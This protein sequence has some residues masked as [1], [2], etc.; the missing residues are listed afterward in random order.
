MQNCKTGDIDAEHAKVETR[1]RWLS[2]TK[3]GK[4]QVREKTAATTA[5][6]PSGDHRKS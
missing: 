1:L 3:A 5:I 2:Q 6:K 4:E